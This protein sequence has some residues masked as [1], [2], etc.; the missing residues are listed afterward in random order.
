LVK[1]D[2]LGEFRSILGKRPKSME[3]ADSILNFESQYSLKRMF[4]NRFEE[5][6]P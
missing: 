4:M 5:P 2:D 1:F 3:D 6:S